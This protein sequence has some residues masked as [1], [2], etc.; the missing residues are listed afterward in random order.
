MTGNEKSSVSDF[1][2]GDVG[3]GRWVGRGGDCDGGIQ[4]ALFAS[5]NAGAAARRHTT[6][7]FHG[8]ER[9]ERNQETSAE[10]LRAN[11]HCTVF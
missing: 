2:G 7:G 3:E 4:L 6:F 8:D 10:S 1:V 5:C 9:V 11:L